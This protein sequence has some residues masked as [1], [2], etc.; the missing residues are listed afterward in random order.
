MPDSSPERSLVRARIWSSARLA[1]M[2]A[3]A[4]WISFVSTSMIGL[5]EAFWAPISTVVVMQSDLT[6]TENSA[7]DRFI[8]TV[9]GALIGWVCGIYWHEHVWVYAAAITVAMFICEFAKLGTAGRLA[10]VTV[11][12]IVL[13]PQTEPMWKVSLIRFVE[14]SWG[15]AVAV[16]VQ[17]TMN[18]V[19]RR[20]KA[21]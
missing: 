13:I 10:A 4:A 16:G 18:W 5:P 2:M 3:I 15:I 14:V 1:L 19:E 9:I 7:R 17:S 12:V 11:S 21:R 6:A 20:G 8:G